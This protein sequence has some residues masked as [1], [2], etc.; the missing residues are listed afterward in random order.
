ADVNKS[1]SLSVTDAVAI[2]QLVLAKIN[3]FPSNKQWRFF[4]EHN[5]QI[6]ELA[7]TSIT[8]NQTVTLNITGVKTGDVNQNWKP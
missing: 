7:N 5:G 1:G 2:S 3:G 4:F 6:V 8:F